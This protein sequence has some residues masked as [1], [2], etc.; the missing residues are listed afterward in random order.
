MIQVG[1][2]LPA[3]TLAEYIEVA[4]NGCSVGP[5]PVDVR[6]AAAGKT[7]AL[8]RCTQMILVSKG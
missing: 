3:A 4:G 6:K 5:N 8:F 7:I 1:D 2:Q